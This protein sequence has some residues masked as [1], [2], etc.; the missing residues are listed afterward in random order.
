[1][2]FLSNAKTCLEKYSNFASFSVMAIDDILKSTK[3]VDLQL[4]FGKNYKKEVS[5]KYQ[6][7]LADN[8]IIVKDI[9]YQN[10]MLY[11]SFF[12]QR[13]PLHSLQ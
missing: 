11:I 10:T 3:S 9:I 1:M 5:D 2:Q 7:L 8:G 13:K 12:L 6:K 4:T